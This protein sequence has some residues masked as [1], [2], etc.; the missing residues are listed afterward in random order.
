MSNFGAKQYKQTAITTASKGQILILLYEAAIRHVKKASE[1][2]DQKDIPG[3]GT[4]IGKAHDIINE[5]ITS[6]DHK[7]GGKVA[8]D[9]ERLYN[10]CIDQ[11][12]QANMKSSKESLQ[13]V[14]KT[15][16]TLLSG[17]REAVRQVETGA[18]T[19]KE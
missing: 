3:K 10:Y 8:E 17:W 9:L 16:G 7:L 14:E 15:L 13:A 2:I 11:L 19:G 4:A 5:L 1:C 12:L 18:K 6:L